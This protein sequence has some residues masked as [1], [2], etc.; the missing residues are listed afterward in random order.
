[1]PPI[2]L[3]NIFTE[4]DLVAGFGRLYAPDPR[5]RLRGMQRSGIVKRGLPQTLPKK[6]WRMGPGQTWRNQGNTSSCVGHGVTHLRAL[7]P[8]LGKNLD[9]DYPF[10]AYRWAQDNDEWEGA[11]PVYYGTS[12]R[13]GLQ[14]LRKVDGSVEGFHVA[15][16][17]DAVLRRLTSPMREGGGPVVVGTDFYSGMSNDPQWGAKGDGWWRVDGAYWGG[18]CWVAF[19]YDPKTA[20]TEEAILCGNSHDGNYIG[21]ISVEEFE[22]LIFQANGDCYAVTE[23]RT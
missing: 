16:N 6:R 5:D 21:R 4:P 18:H 1:M 17:M 20:A 3:P 19:G 13:A 11:E 14:Y 10:R 8:F 23:T 12:V 7:T 22:Y 9:V 15:E 2:E